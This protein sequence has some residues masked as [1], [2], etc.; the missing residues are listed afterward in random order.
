MSGESLEEFHSQLLGFE[1]PGKGQEIIRDGKAREVRVV[2]TYDEG[3]RKLRKL[4][5]SGCV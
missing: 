5:V 4:G 3:E 1:W 2:V